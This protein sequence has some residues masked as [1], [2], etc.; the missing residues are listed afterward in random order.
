M[1]LEIDGAKTVTD[2]SG[3]FLLKSVTAGHHVLKIDGSTAS[4]PGGTYGLFRAGVDITGGKT[5]TLDYTIWMPKLDMANAVTI[6]S[7]T[8]SDVSITTTR[9]PNLELRL[10]VQTVIRDLNGQP[11][12]Q[13]S[14]TPIPNNSTWRLAHHSTAGSTGLPKLYK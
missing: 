5:N 13:L 9:I 2:G 8:T 3:R 12:T 10:P 14:I 1:T 11:V 6:S 4:R 7:P